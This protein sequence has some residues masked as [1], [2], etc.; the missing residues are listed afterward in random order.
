MP[1]PTSSRSAPWKTATLAGMASYLDAA[2]LVTSGIA[3]G[4]Y[5]AAPLRLSPETIGSLLGLQTLA[6]A[7]GALFGGRLGDRLGRRAVFTVSLVLYAAGVLLLLVAA[8]PALLFAGVVTTGL[9]IGAD[10]PVSLALVNEEAPPGRKGTMVVFS[11]MLWLAGIVAVLLLS[12]FM[13]ARGMLGGRI[14]FAHLLIVAVVVLLLRLT[15]SESA[16]WA[17]ARRAADARPAAPGEAGAAIEFGR[18]RDLFR[19]PTV[20]AL[21]A[22]GLYYATWNL[23]ANTLGQ[24]G[25]FLWTALAEGEVAEYSRLTL[26][27]LPVGFVAGLLFMR[28]VDRPARRVWFAA[29]TA[30]IVVAWALPALLGPGRFTLVAVMLVSGLGN[31]FAGESV[32]K[33]WSQE[34]FPTLLRAT[35]TG[36]TMAFTRAL[37][38]L[39]ALG[40]PAFALG[41]TRLF[42]GLLLGVTAVSA[43]IGLVWVPRLP[44]VS[45]AGPL[46]TSPGPRD[47]SPS[48]MPPSP[49]KKKKNKHR[50]G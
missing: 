44:A 16:E 21:L 12:S 1:G 37:A 22:T 3:I 41:H 23:G 19:A 45:P 30:L 38:G 27:G 33:I 8:S 47:P 29:G 11:G 31:S 36:V 25:T 13:G 42:F 28:V 15:L 4:G 6:F 50:Q 20:G 32:Y 49:E 2:A 26:L 9:A 34:L 17:A 35:A 43:V 48:L 39:A 24:F 18:V 5:Y 7:A 46:N 40:T 10:L 14:L